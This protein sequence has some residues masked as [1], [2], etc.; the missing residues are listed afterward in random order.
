MLRVRMIHTSRVCVLCGVLILALLG[1]TVPE[2]RLSKEV[3]GSMDWDSMSAEEMMNTL[4]RLCKHLDPLDF[5][6]HEIQVRFAVR[7]FVRGEFGRHGNEPW[8]LWFPTVAHTF[9]FTADG[10]QLP[11][12]RFAYIV[13]AARVIA[14]RPL[15][16]GAPAFPGPEEDRSWDGWYAIGTPP[17]IKRLDQP[18]ASP[19]APEW[20]QPEYDVWQWDVMYDLLTRLKYLGYLS[21]H[22]LHPLSGIDPEIEY[23]LYLPGEPAFDFTISRDSRPPMGLAVAL[24]L[25]REIA[26]FYAYELSCYEIGHW[27]FETINDQPLDPRSQ[28]PPWLEPELEARFKALEPEAMLEFSKRSLEHFYRISMEMMECDSTT[29]NVPR[30]RE[31]W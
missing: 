20:E 1:C 10:G 22:D 4:E 8:E 29:P 9:L 6:E 18:I 23:P 31:A 16:P 11:P 2:H 21:L 13:S 25:V 17:P 30:W 28:P 3:I 14:D 12:Q 26:Y 24:L 5:D 15:P 7:A 19:R 27:I